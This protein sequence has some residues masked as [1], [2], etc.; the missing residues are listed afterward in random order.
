MARRFTRGRGRLGSTRAT[1]WGIIGPFSQLLNNAAVV[2]TSLNAEFLAKRPFT[3]VRTHM[4]VRI[5]SDQLAADEPQLGAIGC[6]VVSEQASAIGVT[7][8][9][10]PVTDGDSDLWYV[11]QPLLS[12]FDFGSAIGFDSSAGEVY[13]IDSKAMRK[14]NDDEQVLT[15]VEQTSAVSEGVSITG[16]GRFL[17]KES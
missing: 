6:C 4:V 2:I 13:T 11:H 7:A 12:G 16:F 3:I 15:V 1:S 14:V 17:I 8:V 9:P 5:S 10:T